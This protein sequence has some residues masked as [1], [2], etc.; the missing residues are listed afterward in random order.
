MTNRFS[1]A[2]FDW[3]GTLMADEFLTHHCIRTIFYFFGLEPPSI[4]E[5]RL[6]L[7][8]NF[9]PFYYDRGIPR[10]ATKEQLNVFRNA[11]LEHYGD[12]VNLHQGAVELIRYCHSQGM[13]CAIV[14]A[15]IRARLHERL[16]QYDLLRYFDEDDIHSDASTTKQERLATL[17]DKYQISKPNTAFYID[18]TLDG[19]RA[20][21]ALGMTTFGHLGG[22]SHESQ[23]LKAQPTHAVKDL[24]AALQ[25]IRHLCADN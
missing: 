22:Y 13:K 6:N 7:N 20:A 8:S 10:E 14:S 1:L 23:I 25:Q 11:T 5:I 9:M 24:A 19:I 3:N 15:E 16:N 12:K 4:E 2:V 21:N 17:L 18:D